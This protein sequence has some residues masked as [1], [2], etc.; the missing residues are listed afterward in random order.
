M[1]DRICPEARAALMRA[2]RSKDTAPE[3]MVRRMAHRLGSR[4]R[5]HRKD[6]P[7]TPDLVFP[8]L[9]LCIFVNGCFWH[10]H[11]NCRLTTLPKSNVA[12]WQEKFTRNV[13]RDAKSNEELRLLGWRVESIWQCET[14]DPATLEARLRVILQVRPGAP[15]SR[16]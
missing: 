3:L 10:R 2:V 1:T 15:R 13:E 7:G 14:R 11:A 8:R 16:G 5:L 6:L 9:R 4:F 12:F